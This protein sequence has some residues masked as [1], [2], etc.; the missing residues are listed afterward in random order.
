MNLHVFMN[1]HYWSSDMQ[2]F[3]TK[4]GTEYKI[5]AI[6]WFFFFNFYS[7]R[8][9]ESFIYP[10]FYQ[11]QLYRFRLKFRLE[12][13]LSLEIGLMNYHFQGIQFLK[14]N[15]FYKKCKKQMQKMVLRKRLF[16]IK[17]V[18]R[19]GGI[20]NLKIILTVA[21]FREINFYY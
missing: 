4:F 11:E 14:Q 7:G 17:K 16:Q 20:L 6:T 19:I 12:N 3:V 2:S 13:N 10:Q 21:S 15:A 18:S 9:R 1:G 8:K 5:T